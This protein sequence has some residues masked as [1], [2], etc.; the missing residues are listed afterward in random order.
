MN[1]FL[2][3]ATG[4]TGREILDLA[5][6]DGHRV[7][8]FVRSPHK[9]STGRERLSVRQGNALDADA[10]AAAMAGHDA[11]LSALGQPARQA[12]RPSTFMAES[13]ASVV[14]AMQRARARRLAILSAAVLFPGR[15]IQFGFFRWFL[16]HHALDLVAMETIV[17]ASDLDWTIARPP[18]L[19][20][21]PDARYRSRLDA[22]PDGSL[23]VG[24]GGVA[25]FLLAAVVEGRHHQQI[26]GV[27][28]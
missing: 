10:L 13:A 28:R 16:R 27:A 7:T 21:S 23:S 9:L 3:G 24:F 19:V 18:R 15:G 4:K 20:R 8:A 6:R 5:L 26:V 12:L 11:V 17:K 2:L 14:A 25:A 1:L 22:L